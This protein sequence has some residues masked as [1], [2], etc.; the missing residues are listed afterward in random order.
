MHGRSRIEALESRVFL[1]ANPI[2][3]R[4]ID[5]FDVATIEWEGKQREVLAGRWLIA[6]EGYEGRAIVDQL[7][8]AVRAVRDTDP[9]FK[10][11]QFV[12]PGMFLVTAPPTMQ[13]TEV[14]A[15]LAQVPGFRYVHPDFR[16]TT[17]L[18]PN[19]P[20][21][22]QMWGLNQGNDI[23]IDAP[24]AWNS[25][26]G[27]NTVVVGDSDTGVDMNHPDLANNIF[28]NP[29][30]IPNNGLDDDQNG[31]PDD[32][33]G[34]NFIFN[35][36]DASDDADHGTHTS[37]TMAAQGNNGQGI[38]G[39]GWNLK[40]LPLKIGSGSTISG[41]AGTAAMFY[42]NFMKGRQDNPVN[43]RAVN[44]S[45]GGPGFDGSMD[46]AIG[47]ASLQGTFI[48][49]SAGNGGPDFIGDNNDF[50][51]RYPAS[52]EHPNVLAVANMTQNGQREFSSNFGAQSVDLA[53]PGTNVLSTIRT[54]AGSYAFFTGTS[55]AA[56]HVAG[57]VGVLYAAAPNATVTEIRNAILQGVDVMPNWQGVVASGGR[58]NLNRA[59][60]MIAVPGPLSA[61]DMTSGSDTGLSSAD[62]ITRD[63]TPSFQGIGTPGQTIK[64]YANG[65]FVGQTGVPP[66]N[67]FTIT[68]AAGN[69]L[70][71]GNYNMTVTA[72]NANG[73]GA[74]SPPLAITIDATVPVPTG[75]FRFHNSP[76]G[77]N[78]G[79]GEAVGHS[80]ADDD[81]GVMN[82]ATSAPVAA[83]G[84]YNTGTNTQGMSFPGNTTLPEAR[85]RLTVFAGGTGGGITD[86]AGNALAADVTYDFLFMV[87]DPNNDGIVNLNDF[88]IIAANFGQSGRDFSQGDMDYSGNVN[89]NDFNILAGR[90][91]QVLAAP[92]PDARQ[93]GSR[94]I[95]T[96]GFGDAD[97]E[98]DDLLA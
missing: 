58:L 22:G 75:S 45:W 14:N 13:P 60:G 16:Y 68:V 6:L 35:N 32:V 51:P 71:D 36:P 57:A 47:Q 9:T 27:S 59:L 61:P 42:V 46:F 66:T 85:Y 25:S 7:P 49:A 8:K 87:G 89:L 95:G 15:R 17:D 56:P 94:S 91:G 55:M 48:T 64:L 44:H 43:I 40:I 37:G 50:D 69:P 79:F 5:G 26:T 82:M 73:E 11:Q 77:L 31:Y 86:V 83:T 20:F 80:V 70:A 74:H 29:G 88:N 81:F 90:F 18:T 2:E 63:T 76:H 98:Q 33:R 97:D 24:E 78:V 72:S 1:A 10:V 92:A 62:N 52:Y 3:L 19:D 54:A 93:G 41:I 39:V 84:T 28:V 67:V 53:A 96:G 23:D 12:G 30:E 38:T 21:Y 4:K 65:V 34:F